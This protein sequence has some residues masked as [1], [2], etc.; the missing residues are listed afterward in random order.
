MTTET[1]AADACDERAAYHG[2][3]TYSPE[4]NKLR[5]YPF[6][7]LDSETYARLKA[8]GF[9]WAP[10]RNSLLR[11]C[12]RPSAKTCFSSSPA[13]LT[14]RTRA[15]VDRASERAERFEDYPRSAHAT[16]GTPNRELRALPTISHLGNPSSL[17]TTA[18]NAHARTPSASRAGMRRT[19]RMWETAGYWTRRAKGAIRAARYKERPDV[20]HRRIKRLEADHRKVVKQQTT[21]AAALAFWNSADLT[22]ERAVCSPAMVTAYRGEHTT[23]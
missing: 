1:T 15:S 8:A 17:D 5:L 23:L 21:A 9:S 2:T 7:R 6:A 12:G 11:Q 14:T 18:R 16:P 4:D 3:A 10:N 13:T 19:I 20:R 22:H